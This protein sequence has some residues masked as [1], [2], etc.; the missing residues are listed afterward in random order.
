MSTPDYNH[1][2]LAMANDGIAALAA[3]SAGSSHATKAQ[4]SHF[5]CSWM[6]QALK[7][8]RYAKCIADDLTQ[9]VR[10]GRS[11]GAGAELKSLL[12]R[13]S[14]QYSA[15]MQAPTGLGKRL[16]ALLSAAREA[17]FIIYTDTPI[18][19]KLKLDADG[20]S[21]VIICADEFT[22]NINGDELVKPLTLYVRADEQTLA[23]LAYEHTLLL[24]LGDK[25]ASLIKHH[26]AYRLYPHNLLPSLALLTSN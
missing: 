9:W 1:T 10:L 13:I 5:L 23:K 12:E 15:A 6:A 16:N 7:D 17:D 4:Q 14:H 2:L 11:V 24:T 3:S 19:S 25:K 18:K 22:A 26:K 8:R 21:S 20:Q